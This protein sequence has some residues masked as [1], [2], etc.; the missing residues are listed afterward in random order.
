VFSQI[1]ALFDSYRNV[2]FPKSKN[3]KYCSFAM[4]EKLF[5]KIDSERTRGTLSG[6]LRDLVCLGLATRDHA[7]E[8]VTRPTIKVGTDNKWQVCVY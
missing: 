8:V 2:C 1:H 5:Q 7:K 6:E 3:N 4:P